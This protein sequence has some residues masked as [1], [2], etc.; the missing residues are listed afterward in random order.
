MRCSDG[1]GKTSPRRVRIPLRQH[2]GKPAEAAVKEGEWVRAGDAVGRLPAKALSARV[3]ASI[4]GRVTH[5]DVNFG[6]P[7]RPHR[8]YENPAN[9]AQEG[10][11][12]PDVDFN[13]WCGPAPLVK[14]SDRLAPRGVHAFYP[15]FW[16]HDDLFASGSCGDWGAHHLDIAQWGLGLDEG[17]PVRVVRSTAAPSRDPFC[18]GRRQ[19]GEP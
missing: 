2:V 19:C 14:Y 17:G 16:R 10:A 4:D 1:S 7:S 5:V 6:G 11:P 8:D 15:E 18:G 12:N 9:A 13:L 3:H